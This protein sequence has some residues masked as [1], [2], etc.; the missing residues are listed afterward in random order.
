MNGKKFCLL[1]I[2]IIALFLVLGT[3]NTANAKNS[4][5]DVT[6][7][8]DGNVIGTVSIQ[9]AGSKAVYG[10]ENNL[11]LADYDKETHEQRLSSDT[12]DVDDGVWTYDHLE[13]NNVSLGPNDRVYGKD[14]NNLVAIYDFSPYMF[15][16]IDIVDEHGN[17][18][19]SGDFAKMKESGD[20]ITHTFK[21][22]TD[23]D[24]AYTPLYIKD[25][26]TNETYNPGDSYTIG[27]DDVAKTGTTR[28]VKTFQYMYEKIPT[29]DAEI[30][31]IDP[32][33]NADRYATFPGMKP[34]DS[35][36]QTFA[37]LVDYDAV[38]YDF[39]YIVDETGTIYL[40]PGDTYTITY[41]DCLAV[42]DNISKVFEY[43]YGYFPDY[44]VT[45]ISVNPNGVFDNV[46]ITVN[47]EN[48]SAFYTLPEAPVIE[49]KVLDYIHIV[50]DDVN[51]KV[52][53][54]YEAMYDMCLSEGDNLTRTFE[55][56]YK[57]G[58]YANVTV[59]YIVNAPGSEYD[60]LVFDT[61][62]YPYLVVGEELIGGFVLDYPTIS[63]FE[64]VSVT[65]SEK[66]VN[67]VK[68][69]V[70]G[71]DVTD[72][73]GFWVY[74]ITETGDITLNFVYNY[75]STKVD[76]TPE[77]T[78]TPAPAP[79]NETDPVVPVDNNVVNNTN[80]TNTSNV[81][82]KAV[83]NDSN[84]I[85]MPVTGKNPWIAVF[86]LIIFILVFV[87]GYYVDNRER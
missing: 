40:Q 69:M 42:N 38:H 51:Y 3:I 1:L 56:N 29:F 33:G 52:G 54:T 26:E 87:V 62:L 44:T 46:T 43:K 22:F 76:P 82:T 37:D 6:S 86:V 9:H 70:D 32:Q 16:K 34:G 77:P 48:W 68:A 53:S 27:Y 75:I 58:S 24:P 50:E 15:A 59:N 79:G 61:I 73:G 71:S 4:E 84:V 36:T 55:Y 80:S 63:D 18:G 81:T 85:T 14:D 57:E 64:F 13:N 28:M 74:E 31:V 83:S 2:A 20:S 66:I 19:G 60:G 72:I 8:V 12:I 45:Y 49:G 41:D 5:F 47:R 23:V 7:N 25:L 65:Y 78:P 67:G 39:W 17:V 30:T 10:I 35:L 11:G 21:P